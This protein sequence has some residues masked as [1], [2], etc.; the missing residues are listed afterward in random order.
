MRQHTLVGFTVQLVF[1][2]L[3]DTP[4]F[5]EILFLA[6]IECIL[7]AFSRTRVRLSLVLVYNRVMLLCAFSG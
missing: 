6:N 5:Y 4:N 7:F 1:D 2:V 3:L